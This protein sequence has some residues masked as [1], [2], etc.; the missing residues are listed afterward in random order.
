MSAITQ[1]FGKLRAKTFKPGEVLIEQG[2]KKRPLYVLE[3]GDLAVVRDGV[4]VATVSESGA[5]VGEIAALLD[6]APSATVKAKTAVKAYIVSNPVARLMDDPALLLH[7]SRLLAHRLAETT[8]DLVASQRRLA[9]TK[10][11]A[12]LRET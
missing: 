11:A 4:E 7:V 3:S 9:A 8:S 2:S 5:M 10:G 1:L 12:L 6:A